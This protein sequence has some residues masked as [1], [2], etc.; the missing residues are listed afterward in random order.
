M[1]RRSLLK[2]VAAGGASLAMPPLLRAESARTLT[3]VPQSDLTVLDPVWTTADVTRNHGYLVFDTLYGLDA[4]YAPQ[5]QMLAGH[6]I[7]D[8]GNRWRLTLRDG[9]TFHDGTPVRATDV[10]ASLRRWAARDAFGLALMQATDDLA[11]VSDKV[12]QFRLKR[13]F[14]LLPA[15]LGK[16]GSN[17]PCILPERL[18]ATDPF[19]PVTEMIGSGPYRFLAGERVTGSRVVYEKFPSYVPRAGD[20]PSFTAGPKIAHVDRVVWMVIPDATTAAE[21]LLSGEVDWW[22]APLVDL[23]PLLQARGKITVTKDDSQ[24]AIAVMR[25]NFLVPPFDNPAIRRAILPAINQADF[26]TVVAGADRNYWRD[27]VGMFNAISPLATDAGTDIMAGDIDKAKRALAEAGYRGERVVILAPAD[28][29]AINALA[30]V[31][32]DLLHRIG[33]TV[34][35]QELDWGTV[36]QRRTSKQPPDKGGWSIFFTYLQ[37]LNAFTPAAHLGL[38]ANGDQAWVGWPSDSALEALRQDWFAAAD[39]EAQQQICRAIQQRAWQF[40]PYI[41]L[42]QYFQPTAYHR[43]LTGVREGFPQF[44][45]VQRA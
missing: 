17:M 23:V 24:S 25:F 9:L 12:V 40:V 28:Y 30:Q 22:E 34:D 39:L 35:L 2:A 13:P 14:P 29:P 36:V 10:V 11:A 42:G 26:M 6:S 7:E 43:R 45:D 19:K 27:K 31:G 21:A 38:R 33:M 41:P 37:G 44:Y 4:R 5:P 3:F 15:A 1:R 20:Q 8:D 18:A 16:T 32:A